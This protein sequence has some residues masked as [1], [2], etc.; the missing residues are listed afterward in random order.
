MKKWFSRKLW[1]TIGG[2]VVLLAGGQLGVIPMEQA[3]E[4]L[5]YLWMT[6][7]AAQGVTD[8]TANFKKEGQ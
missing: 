1:I 5:T 7:L 4:K 6:Y 2:S 8:V 3:M